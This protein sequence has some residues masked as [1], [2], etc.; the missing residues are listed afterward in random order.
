MQ[1]NDYAGE[2]KEI[3]K[4]QGSP[5]AITYSM[6][7]ARDPAPGKH[8][9]CVAFLRARDGQV[10]DLTKESSSCRGGTWHL[11]LG[12]PPTGEEARGLKEFL[13]RGEKLYCSLATLQRGM[14]L[15]MQPPTGLADHVILSPLEKAESRP[16]II[17]FICNAHQACQLVTLNHY[18]TGLPAKIEMAGSTCHQAVAY[19]I[20]SGQ[21]NVSLMDYT[22]RR[23]G[24]YKTEDL[25]VSVPYHLIPGMM[26]SIDSCTA[27]RAK[28]EFPDSFRRVIG[29]DASD[30]LKH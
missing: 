16:D 1:W 26:Q 3:L 29:N 10:I 17:L 23:I 20:T 22:S 5:I 11:G 30:D 9:V 28:M 8:R 12:D 25:L 7:S 27:G 4:L 19:P 13:V 24:G 14:S 15:T 6:E 21:L 18:D 2:L